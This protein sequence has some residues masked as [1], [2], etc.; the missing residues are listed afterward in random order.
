MRYGLEKPAQ[1][2]ELSCLISTST[3][4]ESPL[5]DKL[6]V[7]RSQTMLPSQAPWGHSWPQGSGLGVPKEGRSVV[8]ADPTE[9]GC[10]G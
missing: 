10:F 7:C 6:W 9:K 1:P 4:S 2:L 5:G 8:I 3:P